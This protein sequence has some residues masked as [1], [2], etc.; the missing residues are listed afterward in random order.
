M[1]SVNAICEYIW[2]HACVQGLTCEE[3]KAIPQDQRTSD[4]IVKAV[5]LAATAA[6]AERAAIVAKVKAERAV[7]PTRLQV[8]YA[9]A[10]EKMQTVHKVWGAVF[11]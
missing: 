11:Y 1:K 3:L 2:I 4:G 10:W 8:Y 7:I 9:E 6:K 5:G